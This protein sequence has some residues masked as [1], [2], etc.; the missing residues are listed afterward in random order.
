MELDELKLA[1]QN[2]DDQLQQQNQINLSLLRDKKTDKTRK[3]LRPLYWGHVLQILLGI[4]SIVLGVAVWTKNFDNTPILISG[5]LIHLYGIALIITA[6]QVMH[7]ITKLDYS[8]PVLNIQKHILRIERTYVNNGWVI[9]LPWWLLWLPFTLGLAA[10]GG[11]DLYAKASGSG[12]VVWSIIF[13]VIGMLATWL[14][15]R[16]ARNPNNPERANRINQAIAGTSL[17]R[18]KRFVQ[19]LQQFEQE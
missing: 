3:S 7:Q 8:A 12:W 19:E 1:W 11:I 13:G 18:A 17:T 6:G 16:W 5:L 2:L 9:G 14:W 15:Y 10:L 4:V